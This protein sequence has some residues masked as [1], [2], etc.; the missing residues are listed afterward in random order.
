M[1]GSCIGR[2]MSS[3]VPSPMTWAAAVTM[4]PVER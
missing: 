4:V 1:T 2:V 3:G